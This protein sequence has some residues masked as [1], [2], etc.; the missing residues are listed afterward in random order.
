[1]ARLRFRVAGGQR[2]LERRFVAT[3]A[4]Q[5]VFDFLTAEGF[6]SPRGFKILSSWPRRDVAEVAD[7]EQSLQALGLFPQETLTLEEK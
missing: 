4:L 5:T 2:T 3:E 7:A 6:E 1:M